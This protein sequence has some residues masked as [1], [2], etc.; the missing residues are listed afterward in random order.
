[1]RSTLRHCKNIL[2]IALCFGFVELSLAGRIV[3]QRG[4]PKPPTALNT[5]RSKTVGF[6]S[7]PAGKFES[8]SLGGGVWTAEENHAAIH[9]AHQRNGKNSLRI[10]GGNR[11]QVEWAVAPDFLPK[12]QVPMQLDF[13]LER[14][15]KREP[16]DF[17]VEVRTGDEWKTIYHDKSK[18][19]VGSFKNHLS[20]PISGKIVDSNVVPMKI[21]F[22]AT[23]PAD[24]GVMIDDI[25]MIPEMPMGVVS[26]K[27]K[28]FEAPVLTR[29]QVNV[30][31]DVQ[32]ETSGTLDPISLTKFDWQ[33]LAVMGVTNDLE[34][35]IAGIDVFGNGL[36]G[37]LPSRN[38]D[39]LKKDAALFGSAPAN[40]R[41][42]R[43]SYKLLPGINHFFV[44]ARLKESADIDGRLSFQPV[45][46]TIAGKTYSLQTKEMHPP[47]RFGIALRKAGDDESSAYRI[48]G[49]ATS[50]KGTLLAV[51]DIRR[52]G[53]RDLPG[54]V[55]V[56]MSRSID[57]G[58]T[59]SPMT[60]IMDMGN[61]PKWSYDGIGDPAI[62]VDQSTG[63]IWCAATWSHGNRSWNGSGPGLKPKDTGQLML[64]K[65]DDDGLTWSKPINIT[66]QVKKPEWC[67][68]LQGP[69]KGITMQDGTIVFAAQFQDTPENKR[70]PRSTILYSKDHGET[71]SL[72][73][74]AFDD[75]TESQVV[76]IEP[77]VL[78]LNCRYNRDSTRVVMTTKDMGKT[79]QKHPTSQR[80][81]IEPRACMGSLINVDA[82][83]GK[84]LAGNLLF[85]NPDS[86]RARERIMVKASTDNGKSWPKG[87]RL[88][89][90][91]GVGAGYSCMTMIDEKT[92]GILY[93]GNSAN[94]IFQRIKLSEL[95][96]EL[97]SPDDSKKGEAKAE[98]NQLG[99]S[100][101]KVFQDHMVMQADKPLQVFGT[102]RSCVEVL[103]TLGGERKSVRS[104]ES[105]CWQAVFASRQPSF[106]PIGLQV[107]AENESISFEDILIGDVWLCAG[108]SNMEW[109]VS[110]SLNK[111]TATKN[112]GQSGIRLFN[113]VG[114]ARGSGGAYTARDF[115][116]LHPTKFMDGKW[117]LAA[118]D[119]ISSFS[120]VGWYFGR[121][122][123]GA[124][125]T[126]ANDSSTPIGLIN[127]SMGGTPTESWVDQGSL[128][129]NS[130]LKNVATG[131][132]LDN[133]LLGEFCRTRGKQ[134]LVPGIQAGEDVLSDDVGPN[135]SFKPGFM[136][137]AAIRPLLPY[138]IRG[139]L[140]YQ[141]ES[142]AE[143]LGRVRQHDQLF[144]VLVKDWRRRWNDELPFLVVQLPG[145]ER[146]FW[147]HFRESQRKMAAEMDGVEFVVTIDTGQRS[148]V[149]PPHK[150]I[151]GERLA[152]LA[153]G[154]VYGRLQNQYATTEI[155]STRRIGNAIEL[156]FFPIGIELISK[157]GMPLRHF[158]VA[159]NDKKFFP[160]IAK[161]EHN[162]VSV[163]SQKVSRPKHVRY[164][165]VP[166]PEPPVNFY[167]KN[168]YPVSPLVLELSDVQ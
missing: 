165:F 160:A 57:G 13:W 31:F 168:G 65:S 22:S 59:W 147:P 15:T 124:L 133:R 17:K 99:L 148:N 154:K 44:S 2:T 116:R 81:L 6:E 19:V 139:V 66:S 102:S 62:L 68:L 138:S 130:E 73:T 39:A 78:M 134:N 97:N 95:F 34:N 117:R 158:E 12:N 132:W 61:D 47:F 5:D 151:I 28:R 163:S 86:L 3:G 64:V 23:T 14:W 76:E 111:T 84:S 46:V 21:R 112:A 120:A 54:D 42:I 103:V 53:G 80:S 145:M 58:K 1:M 110:A 38:S 20:L 125:V 153:L 107:E 113:L 11:H 136:W 72:G 146:E 161:I 79:W 10:L 144:R 129:L 157:D 77:G 35:V 32:V 142:N 141:G 50:E 108:Q 25:R 135:H 126:P 166:F 122:L 41:T 105:G 89:I 55:D 49:L 67:F 52:R 149:H 127:V 9:S 98:V 43:G 70:L 131:D 36:I 27:C 114:A 85:S 29:N 159:G 150:K 121:A 37:R 101:P 40:E 91:E 60:V 90:D 115:E 87:N 82:E 18:A 71:W 137:A 143:N 152:Q 45:S 56:G 109:P 96:L 16:F 155:E 69:G 104:N 24:S 33:K 83:L 75:T 92:V 4:F 63:T 119:S 30:L 156:T 123:E 26:V 164:A 8:W 162:R 51:Y 106:E 128:A 74:G 88:L 100:M 48:P 94:L 93:E 118:A 140:W 167:S 7:V